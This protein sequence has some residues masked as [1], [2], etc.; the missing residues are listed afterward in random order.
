MIRTRCKP[1]FT[2]IELLVVVAIIALLVSI[3]LPSLGKAREQ[4]KKVFC[5]NNVGQ[6]GRAVHIYQSEYKYYPPHAPYP[7]YAFP[8]AFNVGGVSMSS[9][10]WDPNI[11]WLMTYAMRMTPPRKI[12][13]GN[14]IGHFVWYLL[15]EDELPD[16]V[17]CPAA[18]RELMFQWNPE[19]ADP[20]KNEG[21]PLE[22]FLFQYAAFYVTS[23]T[24]RCGTPPIDGHPRTPSQPGEGGTNPPIP[25]PTLGNNSGQGYNNQ[26]RG[27]AGVYVFQKSPNEA[28]NVNTGNYPEPFCWIQ[29]TDPSQ[30]DNPGRVMYL[31]D[32]REYR[33]QPKGM[34]YDGPPGTNYDGWHVGWGNKVFIGTRH[35]GFAN[36]AYMDG[37]SNSDGQ[38]HDI[39][40]N[41]NYDGNTGKLTNVSDI[42]RVST[43]GDDCR[44]AN[45]QTEHHI[46][47]VE[48]VRGWEWFFTAL[49]SK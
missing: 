7:Q 11:G 18:R 34:P 43:W 21:T 36:V 48:M 12:T 42:W 20:S 35:S 29:A 23:G 27:V 26:Q 28:Q 6:F 39:R 9:S 15:S 5:S 19:I 30:I 46:M 10:G 17:V 32:G 3:L 44:V 25:D 4:A 16:I 22:S 24:I 8:P 1:G 40:W 31:A 14:G 38:W 37:H 49:G 41:Y 33:P 45:L 47:P 13:T 2:L